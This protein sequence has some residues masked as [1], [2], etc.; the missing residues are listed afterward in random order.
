MWEAQRQA[1]ETHMTFWSK[2]KGVGIRDYIGEKDDSQEDG[3]IKC[4][5]NKWLPCHAI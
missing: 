2:K 1:I 3:K 4:L 5:V